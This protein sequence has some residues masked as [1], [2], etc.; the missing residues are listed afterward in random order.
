MQ[1]AEGEALEIVV[2]GERDCEETKQ[3]LS[4]IN[5]VYRPNKVVLFKEP[6]DADQLAT[7][8]PFTK[9]Q[10]MVEGKTTVY[11]YRNFACEQPIN[12]LEEL[13]SRLE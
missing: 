7:L 1:F 10:G 11:I 13:K 12:S 8:A 9:E 6:S 5:S 3:M 4:Y 2:V